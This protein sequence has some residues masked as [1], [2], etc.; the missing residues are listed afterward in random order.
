MPDARQEPKFIFAVAHF[1]GIKSVQ[2]VQEGSV[3]VIKSVYETF[4]FRLINR[5]WRNK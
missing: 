4:L 3:K 2:L 5:A 1:D